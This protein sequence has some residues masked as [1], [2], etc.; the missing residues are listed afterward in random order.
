MYVMGTYMF[1]PIVPVADSLL[2]GLAMSTPEP[3][4]DEVRTTNLQVH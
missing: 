2:V 3:Y 1:R 4:A